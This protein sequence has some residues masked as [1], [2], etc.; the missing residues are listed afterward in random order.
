[1]CKDWFDLVALNTNEAF[2]YTNFTSHWVSLSCMGKQFL[3]G[4]L[5][6]YSQE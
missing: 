4:Q 6:F 3:I 1:M 2:V 5:E